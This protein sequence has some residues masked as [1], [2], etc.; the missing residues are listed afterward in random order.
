MHSQQCEIDIPEI[1]MACA[2]NIIKLIAK[3]AIAMNRQ[4]VDD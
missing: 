3:V 2:G 4:E 1:E